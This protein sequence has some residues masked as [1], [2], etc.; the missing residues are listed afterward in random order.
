[1]SKLRRLNNRIND[2]ESSDE[3]PRNFMSDMLHVPGSH[4]TGP[5]TQL[6][7]D[8]KAVDEIDEIARHHDLDYAQNRDRAEADNHFIGEMMADHNNPWT[9]S[10]GAM[11]IGLAQLGRALGIDMT[12]TVAPN[13]K[14]SRVQKRTRHF[15]KNKT[16]KTLK[17]PKDYLMHK[18][19]YE[20]KYIKGE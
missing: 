2:D 5:R 7:K 18:K 17:K 1:M 4:F 3:E 12:K 10:M 20:T 8:K 13:S 19:T 11:G 15:Y 9:A 14:I 16:T 6:T